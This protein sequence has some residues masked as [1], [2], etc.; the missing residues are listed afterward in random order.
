MA[1]WRK[2]FAVI[3]DVLTLISGIH[4]VKERANFGKLSSGFYK[5]AESR[6]CMHLDKYIN[7]TNIIV[8]LDF[9]PTL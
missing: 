2:E 7:I 1:Q 6:T 8:E 4:M 5:H 3:P 9:K